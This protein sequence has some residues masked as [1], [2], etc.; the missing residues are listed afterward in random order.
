MNCSGNLTL[1]RM[2]NLDLT[3]SRLYSLT[4]E[5]IIIQRTLSKKIRGHNF[6]REASILIDINQ[7]AWLWKQL[8]IPGMVR[9]YVTSVLAMELGVSIPKSI[10]A[11]RNSS[12]G[13]IQEWLDDVLE[14]HQSNDIQITD[15]NRIVD[16][17]LFEAWIGAFDRH[18][19]NYLTN[20]KG[21]LWA[22]DF[23]DS[24]TSPV[25]GS[26]LCLYFPWMKNSPELIH[27]GIVKLRQFILEKQLLKEITFFS[28][29][30]K[31]FDISKDPRGKVA[32]KTQLLEI[33][34][35]LTQNFLD[36]DRIVENYLVN[37]SSYAE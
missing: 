36:L 20:N 31:L 25:H 6:T 22:I 28:R 9:E 35:L 37:S 30:S 19:G 32:I 14:L 26:E 7:Q 24:Y 18:G 23:E 13:L 34:E 29:F 4:E 11:K 12:I 16:L 2:I 5:E 17:F 15:K 8:P 3:E 33:Y 10:I 27:H 21:E 1:R